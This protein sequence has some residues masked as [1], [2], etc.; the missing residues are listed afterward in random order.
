MEYLL[1]DILQDDK[2]VEWLAEPRIH[3]EKFIFA[4]SANFEVNNDYFKIVFRPVSA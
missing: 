1:G 3:F 2:L 4:K